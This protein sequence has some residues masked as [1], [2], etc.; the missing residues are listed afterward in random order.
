MSLECYVQRV[1]SWDHNA[2]V[3]GRGVGHNVVVAGGGS[4]RGCVDC[5]RGCGVCGIERKGVVD[6]KEREEAWEGGR[7]IH[8]VV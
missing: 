3:K 8:C 5:G 4:G 1:M 2:C 6:V 7:G